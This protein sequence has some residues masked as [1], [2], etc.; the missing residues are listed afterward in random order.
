MIEPVIPPQPLPAGFHKR[1]YGPKQGGPIFDVLLKTSTQMHDLVNASGRNIASIIS[2]MT[3]Q[4]GKETCEVEKLRKM[5]IE[6]QED[7]ENYLLEVTGIVDTGAD[8][9]CASDEMREGLGRAPLRDALGRI[10]G[11]GGSNC[12]LEKDKLHIVTCDKAITVVES[13][14]I[15]QLGVNTNNNPHFNEVARMELGISCED[16]RFEWNLQETKPHILL[17]LKS[18]S[19]L[20]LPMKEE[21]MLRNNL[22]VPVFSP[23]MQVWRTPLNQ[24]L[25]I[26]GACG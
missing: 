22:E 14:K 13:R 24:K 10:I 19:L 17:G 3:I 6:I 8:V 26:T 18:G 7:G 23:E 12:N 9:S 15:G 25:L 21:E 1:T 5:G 11:I 20:S 2:S 4:V 16:T